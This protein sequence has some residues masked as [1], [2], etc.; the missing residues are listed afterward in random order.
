MY[1]PLVN[2]RRGSLSCENLRKKS[3]EEKGKGA[4]CML[5]CA[6]C[7]GRAEKPENNVSLGGDKGKS[8]KY[9]GEARRRMFFFRARLGGD[10]VLARKIERGWQGQET[11]NDARPKQ[12]VSWR[13]LGE[14]LRGPTPY[15]TV[16]VAEKKKGKIE[17]ER[18]LQSFE[19]GLER[20]ERRSGRGHIA[21]WLRP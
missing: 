4:V 6:F 15:Q 16:G 2:R 7:R 17:E 20:R 19:R 21:C 18:D 3:D 11:I 9:S 8:K 5:T 13:R 12:V 14:N 10:F 1:S